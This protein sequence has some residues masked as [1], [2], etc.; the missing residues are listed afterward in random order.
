MDLHAALL[1][2]HSFRGIQCHTTSKSSQPPELLIP[3]FSKEIKT[4][5]HSVEG[6]KV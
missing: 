2:L 6:N 3:T 5:K 1:C 4:I